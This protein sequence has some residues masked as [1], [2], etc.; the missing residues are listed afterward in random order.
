[1]SRQRKRSNSTQEFLRGLVY[2]LCSILFFFAV[3]LCSAGTVK[4]TAIVL[5][6]LVL[7]AA[8]LSWERMRDR[9]QPPMLAL[10]LVVLMDTVSV[11]YA[12][13]AKFALYEILKVI[14]AFCL[15]LLLLA[16]LGKVRPERGAAVVLEGCCA[17][18]GLVSIDLLSTRWISTPVLSLLGMFTADYTELGVVEIGVRMTSIFMNPNVFAGCIGI[19]VLL[20]LGLASSAGSR[21]ERTAHLVC[22]SVNSLAFILAFSM[23]A[24]AAIVP[25]FLVLLALDGKERRIGLLLLMVETLV[26]TAL[27]AFPI[28]L[29]S[30]TAW[31]GV[32]PVPLLC[33][34]AGAAA[35]CALDLLAGRRLCAKL[36]GREKIALCLAG[37]LAAALVVFLIAACTL[38]TGAT[39]QGG[40]SLRRSAYPKPGSYTV[41][42]ETDGEAS[43]TIR[44]QNRADTMMHTSSVLYS[45]PLSQAAFTVPEDSLVVWFEFGTADGVRLERVDYSGEGGS[46]SVPLGYRLLPAFI[47]NRL[48]GLRANQNA[49]Q[50]F[51]FFE[52]GLK[53][54]LRSPVVGMGMGAFENGVRGV[55]SFLYDTKYAHNHYI[56]ALAETGLVGLALFLGLLA[57][58]ALAVWKARREPLAP[59]LGAALAFM[60]VHGAVEVVFSS[61]PYLPIAFGVFAAISMCGGS[62]LPRP[63]WAETKGAKNGLLIGCCALLAVFGIMLGC[64]LAALGMVNETSDLA[65][66][67]R[68]AALDPFEQADYMLTY[69]VRVTGTTPDEDVRETADRYAERLEDIP[70]NIIP[71]YL[72][73][74]YLDTGRTDEALEQ[75][76]RYVTYVSASADTWQNTFRLLQYYEQDTDAYRAGVAHIADLLDAWNQKNMGHI[77]LDEDVQAFIDRMRS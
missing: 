19:G 8:F 30:M 23:G 9:L 77:T 21:G 75:S 14:C 66:L 65:A 51:V 42:A 48:Q 2:A 68:A 55:Q 11:A 32:R 6:V 54:F 4:K 20:S 57:V 7:S 45:G 27:C 64:N 10:A 16:A 33:T 53:I 5:I 31:D 43:V 13:A 56:Q 46:G 63:A 3:C 62:A 58:S 50:R 59:A 72:A 18:A 44:S 49:I 35:L 40:E 15:A 22:L 60:A 38:T 73:S 25:A 1:M 34:A 41:T 71:Y 36:A 39:L 52:D 28:S 26:I 47:A 24:C 70:S 37:A 61:Y 74:Y 12:A 76:E 67:E 29:T 69:V 17:I